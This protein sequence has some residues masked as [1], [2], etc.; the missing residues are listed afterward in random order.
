LKPRDYLAGLEFHGIKLG[1]DNIRGLLSPA[2]DPQDAYPTVHVAGTNGKG[3]VIAFLDA[4]L[5]AAGYRTGRFTSPHLI[6]VSERFLIDG[7]PISDSDFEKQILVFRE[8]AERDEIPITYFELVTAIAF[9]H[10]KQAQVDIALIEVGMGGRFDATNVLQPIATA[11]TP[12]ALDHMQ[13]LGESIDAIAGEKAGILKRGVPAVVGESRS[14]A[15]EVMLECA[16]EAGVPVKLAGR[17]FQYEVPLGGDSFRY[18]GGISVECASLGVTG[19]HQH[20]NAAVAVA[21]AET[22]ANDFPRL[23][24]ETI[25]AGLE[26]VRWPCRLERVLE[27]PPVVIDSGHNPAAFEAIADCVSS[28]IVVMAVSNDKQAEAMV[29]MAERFAHRMVLTQYAGPRGMP[30]EE[31]AGY[32]S[33]VPFET[34]ATIASAIDRAIE[35]GSVEQPV[36]VVGSIFAA[37][38]A[39]AY[40]ME[41]YGA[42]PLQF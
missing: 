29:R 32:V 37:G 35:L 36:L 16:E 3:S 33:N 19:P 34:R 17:D 15:R 8:I 18:E 24:P 41:R 21:L 40:L 31:L 14:P 25:A 23:T 2:G 6:D 9:N 38:E 4:A 30:V 22:I 10:F 11:I 1:L 26:N 7:T 28:G 42:P 20:G 5:R 12:I 27:S 13:Y 39:R